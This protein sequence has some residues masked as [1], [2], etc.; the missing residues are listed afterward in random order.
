LKKS[1]IYNGLK[2]A[3]VDVS[4]YDSKVDSEKVKK[5]FGI[6]LLK[7]PEGEYDFVF[8]NLRCVFDSL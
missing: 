6:I 4:I 1:E 3:G 8:K 7:S 2:N 5:E